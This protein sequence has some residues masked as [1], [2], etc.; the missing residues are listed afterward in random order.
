MEVCALVPHRPLGFVPQ[1]PDISGSTSAG[2]TG[3]PCCRFLRNREESEVASARYR[4]RYA[5]L[6][7]SL[8]VNTAHAIRAVLFAR[9]IAATLT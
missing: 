5:N 1:P 8:L 9:A 2:P 7:H 3:S 6:K 4:K